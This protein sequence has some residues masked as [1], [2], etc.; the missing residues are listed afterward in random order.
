VAT[1]SIS[2]SEA[3]AQ[4]NLSNRG[5]DPNNPQFGWVTDAAGKPLVGST[6]V[7]KIFYGASEAGLIQS[8]AASP[9]RD[10]NT[11]YPGTWNPAAAG[12]PGAIATLAGFKPGATV[13]LKVA[14]WDTAVFATWELAEAALK[15]GKSPV[16]TQA[17]LSA[18]FT[19]AIP[20]DSLAIP[21]GLEKFQGLKL[22]ALSNT[23]PV[24]QAPTANSQNVSVALGEA[25]DIELT[26]KDPENS[27]LTYTIITQP[28]SG[29]LAG[30]APALKYTPKAGFSGA[31]SFTFKVNDGT[32]DSAVATVSIT[33]TAV[34]DAPYIPTYPTEITPPAEIWTKS[35]QSNG[36][37]IIAAG[38]G[39]EIYVIGED[40][41]SRV[42]SDGSLSW[43][44][45]LGVGPRYYAQALL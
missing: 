8:F 34:N 33:V 3:G 11:T 13:T 7:A 18:A 19:Y 32:A 1:I 24:N 5:L 44:T 37:H 16:P 25:K 29:T 22:T 38:A 27:K 36:S 30:I 26:A 14:V 21:G 31:D 9:F 42:E 28:A 12:G 6:Y 20:T 4:I 2:S 10:A 45:S 15:A 35:I 17:G 23:G 39:G 41:L 40:R 43:Q